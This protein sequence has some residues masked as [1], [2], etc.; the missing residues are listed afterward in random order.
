MSCWPWLVNK[1]Y[2]SFI[3]EQFENQFYIYYLGAY[4]DVEVEEDITTFATGGRSATL[5]EFAPSCSIDTPFS[6]HCNGV[7][8]NNRHILTTA[9]CVMNGTALAHPAWIRVVCGN[10]NLFVASPGRFVSTV[11]HVYPHDGFVPNTNNNDLA[12][13]R[14][15]EIIP[16]PSNHIEPAVFNNQPIADGVQCWY[17]G[18]GRAAMA[19]NVLVVDKRVISAPIV[20]R[21]TC[22]GGTMANPNRAL[23]SMMCAGMTAASGTVAQATCTGNVGG[24]LYCDN[25][26]V[27][28]LA[29]GTGCGAFNHPG[30][31]IQTRLY[32]TWMNQQIARTDTI[33]AGQTYPRPA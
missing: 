21:N 2:F 30:I 24:A 14:L 31:Y 27:G 26:V 5:G 17:A 4:C 23:E 12:I 25:Q 19:S 16:F 6:V 11:S 18:W 33:P 15:T 1:N 32:Q 20:N 29:L 22:N 13:L 8:V 28:I 7:V 3:Y 10:N 9:S